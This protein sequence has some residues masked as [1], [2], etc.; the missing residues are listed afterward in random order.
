MKAGGVEVASQEGVILEF[1][2]EH[3][4]EFIWI[5]QEDDINIPFVYAQVDFEVDEYLGNNKT[6]NLPVYVQAEGTVITHIGTG[7]DDVIMPYNYLK[8]YSLSQNLYYADELEVGGGHITGIH[9]VN[10]FGEP[11]YDSQI[12]IWMGEIQESDLSQGWVDPNALELVFEGT[13]DF[14]QGI[15]EVYIPLQNPYLYSGNNLVIYSYKEDSQ[16]HL[17]KVFKNTYDLNSGRSR[18]MGQSSPFDPLNPITQG[19]TLTDYFPNIGIYFNIAGMATLKG[20][21]SSNGVPIEGVEVSIENTGFTTTTDPE[22]IYEFSALMEGTYNVLYNQIGFVP[23]TEIDVIISQGETVVLD[24]SLDQL[25]TY[26]VKGKLVGEDGLQLSQ[27]KVYLTGD[28]EYTAFTNDQGDFEIH[29]VYEGVY[30][31]TITSFAYKTHNESEIAII[32]NSNETIDLEYFTLQEIIVPPALLTVE[33]DENHRDEAMLSWEHNFMGSILLVDHDASNAGPSFVNAGEIIKASLQA[34]GVYFDL[35]ESSSTPPY[36]GPSY[37]I[38]RKYDGVIW[39]A[40]EGWTQGQ[41]MTEQDTLYLAKYIDNGGYLL[42][43]GQD[44]L[45]DLYPS[46]QELTF[47]QGQFVYDYF[48]LLQVFQDQWWHGDYPTFHYQHAAGSDGSFAQG[49]TLNLQNLYTA[50]EGL[51]TDNIIV[52]EGLPIIDIL[53]NPQ[54]VAAIKYENTIFSSASLEAIEDEDARTAFI[55]RGLNSFVENLNQKSFNGYALYLNEEEV[56]PLIQDN[57]YL[58][59]NLLPNTTYKAAVKS[60]YT[61][62]E[63]AIKEI[64]FTTYPPTG[65]SEHTHNLLVYPNPFHNYIAFSNAEIVKRVVITNAV[66]QRVMDIPLSG[67]SIINTEGL[68]PGMYIITLELNDEETVVKR[69]IKK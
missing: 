67:K 7:N 46:N 30:E 47:Q 62:G 24:V 48:G 35:Y 11:L 27:A 5:P 3:E 4:Y 1:G 22:G 18:F 42:F 23:H 66:G 41:T 53:E 2:E 15:K 14:P 6:A 55:I 20:V 44:F 57:Q 13:I 52:H 26:T 50:K 40:G 32:N 12:S 36:N 33:L 64:T 65:V 17:S 28:A 54:G 8:E 16:I 58:F 68:E 49:L 31:I 29:N 61:S 10:N 60:L 38:M 39:I 34:Q 25:V 9:Y 51:T 21:V 45:Y 63:S 69:V 59:R 56:E 37:E 19:S 43:S